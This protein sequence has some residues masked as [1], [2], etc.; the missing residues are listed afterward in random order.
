VTDPRKLDAALSHMCASARQEQPPTFDVAGVESRIREEV[1]RSEVSSAFIAVRRRTW[2]VWTAIVAAAAVSLFVTS[3]HL[4]NGAPS[5]PSAPTSGES[6]SFEL[7]RGGLERALAKQGGGGLDGASLKLGQIVD[8][9][10]RDLTI[11]H[12]SVATW[13]L[14]A[15]GRA[16]VVENGPERVTLALDVGLLQADVVPQP[17]HESFAVEV[18]DTRVAVHGTV[19]S[20][21]RRGDKAEVIVREGKVIVGNTN[22]RGDT[23]GTLLTAPSRANLDL[24][25]PSVSQAEPRTDQKHPHSAAHTSAAPSS[26]VSSGSAAAGLN[27]PEQPGP[28]ELDRAWT[29]VATI[30]STCFAE[31][32]AGSPSVRVSFR[33]QLSLFISSLGT[34]TDVDFTPPVP[35]PVRQCTVERVA[36][37]TTHP[38]VQ[39][40]TFSRPILLTR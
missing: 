27:A 3:R 15:G 8:A 20:V 10:A 11:R 17:R 12:P 36:R 38:S 35:E 26:V 1:S 39:G 33:T 40:A 29:E 37:V 19:F 16:H 23:Q 7:A 6:A 2:P 14:M 5:H 22:R 25:L 24:S 18:E 4:N 34:L 21:E 32:T 28:A 30:V 31:H 13:R 9:G